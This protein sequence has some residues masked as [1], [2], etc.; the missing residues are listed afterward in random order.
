MYSLVHLCALRLDLEL[1]PDAK[2]EKKVWNQCLI[3]SVVMFGNFVSLAC[4]EIQE[5]NH[6]A[7]TQ[8]WDGPLAVKGQENKNQWVRWV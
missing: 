6:T 2:K 8:F 5:I 7:P 4:S 1:E 3:N